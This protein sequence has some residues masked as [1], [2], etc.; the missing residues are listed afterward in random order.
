MTTR[1]KCIELAKKLAKERDS[2]TCQKPGCGRSKAAGDQIHAGH[3]LPVTYGL[4]AANPDNLIALCARCHTLS[5]YS[6]H[7]N[8][9][10]NAAWFNL[11][12]P[13]RYERLRKI[14]VPSRPIKEAEWKEILANLKVRYTTVTGVL[15]S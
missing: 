8:P 12:F 2:Y 1:Q 4:T 5:P 14:A 10:E 3:I 15:D 11:K 6:W 13:G 7:Q 9:I